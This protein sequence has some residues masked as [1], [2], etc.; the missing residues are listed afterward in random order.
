MALDIELSVS[1]SADIET[2][3]IIDNTV[4]GTGGNPA[5]ADLRVFV[6]GYKVDLEGNQTDLGLESNDGDPQTDSQWVWDYTIDGYHRFY[7]VAI[8]EYNI[9]TSYSQ[10]DA[11]FGPS[12][13]V[14][15]SLQNGNI[16]NALVNTAFWEVISDP[17]SLANNEGESNES[18]NITSLIYLRVLRPISQQTYG[19]DISES[20]ACTDCSDTKIIP[21]YNKFSILLNGAAIADSRQEVLKGE[22]ICRKI[23]SL[24]IDC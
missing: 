12:N 20:C 2:A 7:Y 21:P 6:A 13:I 1:V 19:N 11:V 8:P 16:G 5:R 9:G 4:Y 23:Q 10:Y 22:L 17:A 3:T 24:F 14:Y 15:R 18:E